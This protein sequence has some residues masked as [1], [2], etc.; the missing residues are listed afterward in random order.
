MSTFII[1][2]AGSNHNG[3][4]EQAYKLIEVAKQCGCDAVKFQVFKS[5][6]LYSRYTPDFA[7][8]ND[9]PETMKSLELPLDWL[10]DLKLRCE[11]VDIEFMATPFDEES[12]EKLVGLEVERLKVASFE[13]TDPRFIRLVAKTGLPL[14]I[15]LGVGADARHTKTLFDWI[16]K[17][18]SSPDITF[19][20][21]NS[22][23]PT[24]YHDAN[25]GSIQEFQRYIKAFSVCGST[26]TIKN[27]NLSVGLSDHTPGILIPPV[28][29]SMGATT[30]EKHFTLSRMLPGPDHKYA[31][32]PKELFDMVQQIRTVEKALGVKN[33]HVTNSERKFNQARRSIVARRNIERNEMISG[34][35]ITTKRPYVDGSI[36][37][38]MYYS[39]MGSRATTS[40][41]EDE[42]LDYGGIDASWKTDISD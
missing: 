33:C 11:Q 28:A 3:N 42:I 16:K 18:N 38:T 7:G 26:G 27:K 15:S 34:E 35:N 40:I 29:V 14:V 30:I 19:L 6:T 12:I 23:Y 4:L 21:C 2:E 41:N 37:A 36:P 22:S 9:V 31:L 25:L 1:A 13:S 17:D 10:V 39:I 24:P 5:S 8:Y 20:H 32:E